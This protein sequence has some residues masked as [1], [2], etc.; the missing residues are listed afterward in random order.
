LIADEGHVYR[1]VVKDTGVGFETSEAERLF[2]PFYKADLSLTRSVGGLGVGLSLARDAARA[3]GGDIVAEGE[4]GRGAVFTVALPLPPATEQALTTS[5]S[6]PT[7]DAEPQAEAGP[8]R[9]L[10]ADDHEG[11]RR[12]VEL[13]LDHLGAEVAS[14]ENGAEAVEAFKRSAFD[15]VLMDLQMP[16]MDGLTAI[17]QIRALEL[18]IGRRTPIIVLSANAQAQHLAASAAAGADNHIG[19]PI[20]APTLIAALEA[21]LEGSGYADGE[22]HAMA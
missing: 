16:V 10:L 3:M 2:K 11:N 19:K 13:I 14:V 4:F 8:L 21:V 5:S 15:V 17:R 20:L 1:I 18:P 12:I 6:G 7:P 22:A 9:V